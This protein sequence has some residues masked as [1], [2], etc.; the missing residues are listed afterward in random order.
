MV[1]YLKSLL[2]IEIR[3]LCLFFI[4]FSE[5]CLRFSHFSDIA[6]GL[7]FLKNYLMKTFFKTMLKNNWVPQEVNLQED[8]EQ[9]RK[10]GFLTDNEK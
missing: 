7:K 4:F 5:N 1:Q 8:I 2:V 9:W 3:L 10:P 6:S